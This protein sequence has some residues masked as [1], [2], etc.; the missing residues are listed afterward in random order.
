MILLDYKSNNY[1]DILKLFE[2]ECS[3]LRICSSL[4]AST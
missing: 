1:A 3:G 4:K 2:K